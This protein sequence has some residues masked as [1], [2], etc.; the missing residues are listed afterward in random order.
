MTAGGPPPA[1]ADAAL[2][3]E[4]TAPDPEAD[5][6]SV[7]PS[8]QQAEAD[9]KN[10]QFQ[11]ALQFAMTAMYKSG[12]SK[13]I[14]EQLR[15]QSDNAAEALANVAYEIVS[16]A[17]ERVGG[18]DEELLMLFAGYI[19][20]EVADIGHAAGVAI[21][22]SDLG[23]AIKLMTLRWLGENGY[24]TSELQGAMDKFD[25]GAMDELEMSSD[26]GGQQQ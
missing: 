26:A 22:P 15:A 12:A 5:D 21:K 13:H 25:T 14:A 10:P 7:V 20:E 8:E 17:N 2:E 16:M 11:Q 1:N 19:L 4:Q 3:E 9:E 6:P 23:E 24:D 18:I